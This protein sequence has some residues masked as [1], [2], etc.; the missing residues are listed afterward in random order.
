M[1]VSEKFDCGSGQTNMTSDLVSICQRSFRL[2]SYLIYPQRDKNLQSDPYFLIVLFIVVLVINVIVVFIM[3]R[4]AVFVTDV[5]IIILL[6]AFLSLLLTSSSCQNCNVGQW[7][8][9]QQHMWAG[10]CL[11]ISCFI[12]VFIIGNENVYMPF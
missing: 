12:I 5:S 4:N 8:R 2:V 9:L 11:L 3:V 1:A 6:S 7:P 10:I